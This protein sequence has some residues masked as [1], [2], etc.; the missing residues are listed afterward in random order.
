M[1]NY[2]CNDL[3]LRAVFPLFAINQSAWFTYQSWTKYLPLVL[4]TISIIVTDWYLGTD[5]QNIITMV[6][7][8]RMVIEVCVQVI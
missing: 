2:D 4:S 1:I 8:E 7:D 6:S 3:T 5:V